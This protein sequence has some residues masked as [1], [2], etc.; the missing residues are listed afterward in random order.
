M[1]KMLGTCLMLLAACLLLGCGGGQ[2]ATTP[3]P[4]G[5]VVGLPSLAGLAHQV[6]V[7]DNDTANG[8]AY[9]D[10]AHQTDSGTAVVLE[11][12]GSIPA[13]YAYAVYS[14]PERPGDTPT[15][16]TVNALYY[17]QDPSL[18]GEF[19]GYWIAY[20]DFTG[21]GEGVWR[22]DG[23][24]MQYQGRV[25]IPA[26]MDVINGSG[27]I[28]AAVMLA[29]GS[30][31]KLGN[32]Q[33][34]YDAGPGYEEYRLSPPRGEAVGRAPQVVIDS[35]GNP[36]VAYL[37][38]MMSL[39]DAPLSIKIAKLNGG[40]WERETVSMPFDFKDVY[41]FAC[42]DNGRRALLVIN[43][44]TSDLHLL[45]D[46]GSGTWTDAGVLWVNYTYEASIPD[47]EFVNGTDTPDGERDTALAV[48]MG[49]TVVPN[50]DIHFYEYDG[51][52]PPAT[53]MFM[54]IR[55]P[56]RLSLLVQNSM[57]TIA[58]PA[59]VAY[60][61][62]DGA[63][64]N[65]AAAFNF[66]VAPPV[67]PILDIN[68]K[69]DDETYAVDLEAMGGG[70]LALAYLAK[71]DG[72][73]I[74]SHWDGAIWETLVSDQ[75]S[76]TRPEPYLQIAA[77]ADGTIVFPTR[78]A[79]NNLAVYEGV[80]G[81]GDPFTLYPLSDGSSNAF[82]ATIAVSPDDVAHIVTTSLSSSR[83]EYHAYHQGGTLDPPVVLDQGEE[84]FGVY[85][86]PCGVVYTDDALHV[87]GMDSSHFRILHSENRNGTWVREA[88][89]IEP[90]DHFS[91]IIMRAGYLETTGQ[92]WVAYIDFDDL[93][94]YVSYTDPPSGDDWTW[95][96]YKLGQ[97]FEGP[98]AGVEDDETNLAFTLWQLSP[99]TGGYLGFGYAPLG[100]VDTD[101]EPICTEYDLARHPL[102]MS[103]NKLAGDWNM[104]S[105]DS[106]GN[107]TYL[108][109]RAGPDNWQ[110]PYTIAARANIDDT[111]VGAG[112]TYHEGTG[113][114]RVLVL[115]EDDVL[116]H[117]YVNI[118]GQT[119]LGSW[120]F[121]PPINILDQD[122]AVDDFTA[123]GIVPDA[124]GNPFISLV[125]KP[126][127]DPTWDVEFYRYDGLGNWA[128]EQTW[129]SPFIGLPMESFLFF[130]LVMRA[131][132]DYAF[133]ATEMASGSP[134]FG[135][136]WSYYPW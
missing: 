54:T 62:I 117:R 3:T 78:Y 30:R 48:F 73:I 92:L 136:I 21:A 93:G 135:R 125:V 105:T 9:I 115:E 36:Q 120:A 86:G 17:D 12:A 131:N 40:V 97:M 52:N 22:F 95:H 35:D 79:G 7:V 122:R 66:W 84:G 56:D 42:G 25:T 103:Y 37:R 27:N 50:A 88:E 132:G 47:I 113:L 90:F 111:A 99:L 16:I 124:D 129:D 107:R 46:G 64:M 87:F 45:W 133:V 108:W 116:D 24:F 38:T 49:N 100:Q 29:D 63:F 1:Q 114:A 101:L 20:G 13:E 104:L 39:G 57:A 77:F 83:L 82:E 68:C 51:I 6:S 55:K 98:I 130:P 67:V 80:P 119:A 2:N 112:I 58:Y 53:A 81:S 32:V 10:A 126:V 102:I 61:Q 127:A 59:A 60:P 72:N 89:P 15:T 43:A 75:V 23:P 44:S 123:L 65:Y 109:H 5:P 33:V 34:G 18:L 76:C 31:M 14:I 134:G 106:E 74:F 118:Y 11:S 28:F 121:N 85:F 71:E 26:G 128:V 4:Q 69:E 41:A 94:V 19:E 96:S 8:S 70:E 110:G 91:Y